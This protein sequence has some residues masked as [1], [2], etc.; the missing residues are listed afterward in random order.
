[1]LLFKNNF[2]SAIL[3]S[4][5]TFDLDC[6]PFLAIIVSYPSG[7]VAIIVSRSCRGSPGFYTVAYGNT[8]QPRNMLACFTPSGRGSCYRADGSIWFVA[9]AKAGWLTTEDCLIGSRW[10]WPESD[11]KL[12]QPITIQVSVLL[13]N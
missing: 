10:E 3:S 7:Q 13:Y 5:F 11:G 8:N 12:E 6:S 4:F 1:L 2:T 9:G